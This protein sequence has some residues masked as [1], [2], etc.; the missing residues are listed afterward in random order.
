MNRSISIRACSFAIAAALCLPTTPVEAAGPAK[1]PA[2][3]PAPATSGKTVALLRFGGPPPSRGDLRPLVQAKLE[4]NGF[5]IKSVALDLPGA[6]AKVKCK[7]APDTPECFATIGK[8][9]NSSPKTAADFIV[10]GT[11]TAGTPMTGK[12]VVYDIAKGV[13]VRQFDMAIAEEDLVAREVL[14][15]A[16]ATALVDH[17]T[18][19]APISEAEQKI[20]A[21]LDEPE[22][23]PEQIAAEQKAIA[24]A[25]ADAAREVADAEVIDTENI[26]V[27]LRA[28]F[29]DFC[30]T[31]PR[32]KRKSREDP[33]DLRPKCQRGPIFG[34]WQPRAWVAL[35]LTLGAGI[36]TIAAY[37]LAL[38]ARKPYK[39]AVSDV[40]AYVDAAGGD[41]SKDPNL[42]MQGDQRYDALA[43]EVSRTGSIMRRRAIVGD[44]LLGT[45][46]L[47]T[48][49][50]AIII[51]QDRTDAKNFI[52]QEKGLRA[53]SKT[54]RLA[55]TFSRTGAGAGM[56]FK[57]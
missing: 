45:T 27:D 17:M 1:K 52:K 43:T 47:L 6:A 50:L 20:I 4:E 55:P 37:S 3:A 33:K 25:E 8:W 38:V 54:F 32:K 5:S 15:G 41:P 22:K 12:F 18:P 14:P 11:Y 19:P 29:K 56:G 13:V 28:D 9:L 30:R 53:I 46:V 39:A 10:H 42:A 23:T 26:P 57:F 24:D 51:F 36:G 35:T 40:D 7:G 48:G 34:Y 21:S 16:V 44:V 31:G 49:V 2:A